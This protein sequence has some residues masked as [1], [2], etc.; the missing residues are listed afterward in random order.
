[1]RFG[2]PAKLP[3]HSIYVRSGALQRLS[4]NKDW[5]TPMS[6]P[7]SLAIPDRKQ[8]IGSI[9]KRRCRSLPS[10]VV[11]LFRIRRFGSHLL[12]QFFHLLLVA[13]VRYYSE[14]GFKFI[15]SVLI[16]FQLVVN[17]CKLPVYLAER[18]VLT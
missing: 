9:R 12:Y 11:D 1:M 5:A 17:E 6:G 2:L 10:N 13:Y 15:R 7:R 8:K 18:Q 4:R 16:A 14:I 3:G